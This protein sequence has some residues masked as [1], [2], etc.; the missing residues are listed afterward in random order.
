MRQYCAQ[1]L[2]YGVVDFQMK[3]GVLSKIIISLSSSEMT[4]GVSLE[5]PALA[6]A[7]MDIGVVGESWSRAK[8]GR[9]AGVT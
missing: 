4:I 8:T 3:A 7:M 2:L 6:L 5:N 1:V 9:H